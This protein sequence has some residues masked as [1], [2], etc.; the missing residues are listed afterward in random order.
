M[1]LYAT[2]CH[3]ILLYMIIYEDMEEVLIGEG[4]EYP[5]SE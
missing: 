5:E 3:Y 1:L 2:I 4:Y